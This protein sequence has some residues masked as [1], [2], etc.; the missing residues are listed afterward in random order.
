[1]NGVLLFIGGFFSGIVFTLAA[2]WYISG[3]MEKK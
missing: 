3:K 2:G 1:M